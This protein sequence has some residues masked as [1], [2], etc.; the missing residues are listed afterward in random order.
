MA[1]R[2]TARQASQCGH[3]GFHGYPVTSLPHSAVSGS[4]SVTRWHSS[5]NPSSEIRGVFTQAGWTFGATEGGA[6]QVGTGP[7]YPRA[8][9][10]VGL[11]ETLCLKGRGPGAARQGRR[12]RGAAELREGPR[13][14]HGGYPGPPF[15]AQRF[16]EVHSS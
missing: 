7:A 12:S 4:S 16:L 2:D 1:P 3:G 13:T 14:Q 5:S 11:L 10:L 8:G 15:R 9:A 6:A